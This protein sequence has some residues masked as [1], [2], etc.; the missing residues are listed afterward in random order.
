MYPY[1]VETIREITTELTSPDGDPID[2]AFKERL[3][4]RLFKTCPNA[5]CLAEVET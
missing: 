4:Q 2:A 5:N 3:K 1:L